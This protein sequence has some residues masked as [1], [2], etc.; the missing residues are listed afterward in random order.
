M[1]ISVEQ[2]G[3]YHELIS[4]D[5]ADFGGLDRVNSTVKTRGSAQ[6]PTLNFHLPPFTGCVFKSAA[7]DYSV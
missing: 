7:P 4:T 2:S 3:E 5:R 1:S 6:R